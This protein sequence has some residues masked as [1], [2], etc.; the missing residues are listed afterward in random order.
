[1][2]L[3]RKLEFHNQGHNVLVSSVQIKYYA[4]EDSEHTGIAFKTI[5]ELGVEVLLLAVHIY[6][7]FKCKDVEQLFV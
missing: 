7:I 3:H 1:M 2:F 5:G 6:T 4:S